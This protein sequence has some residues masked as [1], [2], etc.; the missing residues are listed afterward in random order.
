MQHGRT[1]PPP[2]KEDDTLPSLSYHKYNQSIC[3]AYAKHIL[4][5]KKR[6]APKAKAPKAKAPKAKAKKAGISSIT[7]AYAKLT[8]SSYY[9]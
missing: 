2:P 4:G 9:R 7:L 8:P 6:V 1:P 5:P 3:G